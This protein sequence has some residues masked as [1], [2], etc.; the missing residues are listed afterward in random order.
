LSHTPTPHIRR[1]WLRASIFVLLSASLVS[2][3]AFGQD[4]VHEWN[5]IMGTA[6][7]TAGTNPIVTSR[8][9]ALVQAAVFDAVNGIQG[10]YKPIHVTA[11]PSGRTSERAAAIQAAYAMLI[12]LYPAQMASLTMRR[13]ASLA[14]LASGSGAER[15]HTIQ[16]G[17]EWGQAVA[18]SIWAWRQNDGFL[19]QPPPAFHGA[20]VVGV[21]RRTSAAN[22]FG[23]E[24]ASMTPWVLE[25][26]SQFR[27][28]PPPALTSPEY[29]VDYD[30]VKT[31]GAATG[32]PRSPDESELVLFWNG[33][34]TLI[35][36][37]L[38]SRL[39]ADRGLSMLQ[40][41]RLLAQLNLAVADAAIACWDAKYRFVFWR[42]ITAVRLAD[43]DGN[44]D[45][46]ADPLW[47]TWLAA[48]PAHPEYLSGHSTLSGAAAFVLASAFG[49]DTAFTVDSDARPGLRGF[50]NFADALAEVV[51]ARV[52]GGIHFRTACVRGNAVGRSVA[53]YV[54]THTMRS[55]HGERDDDWR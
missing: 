28:A 17:V 23:T 51:N 3:S 54:L 1:A 22:G 35:W 7:L 34:G 36:N 25:R 14:A 55:R 52:F 47:T 5:A 30:E 32:S 38:A 4:P 31:W 10:R 46:I 24:F 50:S 42:P 44:A 48:T 2:S 43:T 19:P 26:P 27:P 20:E 21:W 53:D 45:T 11:E 16:R 37:R 40:T 13:D 15:P 9:A 6:V 39:A 33:N 8:V 29:T 18:D 41:A 49:E 12:R